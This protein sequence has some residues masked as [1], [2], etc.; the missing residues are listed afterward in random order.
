MDKQLTYSKTV[1]PWQLGV[2]QLYLPGYRGHTKATEEQDRAGTDYFVHMNDGRT[3]RVDF[4]HRREDKLNT[5]YWKSTGNPDIA[6][7]FDGWAEKAGCDYYVFT[8]PPGLNITT[9]YWVDA[10]HLKELLPTL[11]KRFGHTIRCIP[12]D[13]P[14]LKD[15]YKYCMFIPAAT[16]LEYLG[17]QHSGLW[18]F[19]IRSN[20][21]GTPIYPCDAHPSETV[22]PDW[23]SWLDREK[24]DEWIT[25]CGRKVVRP[26]RRNW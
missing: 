26:R 19:D 13:D 18:A 8:Y 12:S 11:K 10:Q 17:P 20:N 2:L 23:I 22:R 16:L 21:G 9:A 24:D 14:E 6:V 7:E 5:R 4:K 15:K 3:L 25:E 1:E